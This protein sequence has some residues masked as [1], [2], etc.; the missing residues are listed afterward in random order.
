[1][2]SG[3]KKVVVN[4]NLQSKF[5]F[6]NA[7]Q[8]ES[9]GELVEFTQLNNS[10][11]LKNDNVTAGNCIDIDNN[12][13]S[14]GIGDTIPDYNTLMLSG[15]GSSA[16][17]G[18]YSLAD[19]NGHLSQTGQ[20]FELILGVDNNV[21]YKQ[22]SSTSW[23]IIAKRA[24]W[25]W[26]A[27]ANVDPSNATQNITDVIVNYVYV[28][29]FMITQGTD[30]DLN[31]DNA[32]AS[33]SENVTY[34]TSGNPGGITVQN[35]KAVLDW[36]LNPDQAASTKIFPS[37]VIKQY[38]DEQ[39]AHFANAS[40][41]DFNNTV[42]QLTG[43]PTK[44]QSA[45]EVLKVLVD[46]VSS[47]VSSNQTT[48]G[49]EYIDI[50]KLQSAM[51]TLTQDI[52][53]THSSLSDNTTVNA[54]IDELAVLLASLRVDVNT[55][56]GVTDVGS[57]LSGVGGNVPDGLDVK[58][59]MSHLAT[60]V[61]DLASDQ[62]NRLPAAHF[63]HYV[64]TNATSNISADQFIGSA[65][66]D[67]AQYALQDEF[68]NYLGYESFD[69][70]VLNYDARI[71]VDYGVGGHVN[72][73]IYVR[74][75]DTGT[76]SRASFFDEA[77]EI[78]KGSHIKIINGGPI[79]G[80]DFVVHSASNPVVGVDPIEF[81]I[82]DILF[83]GTGTI[84]KSKLH[85]NLQSELD[86]KNVK[87][88]AEDVGGS[89]VVDLVAGVGKVIPHSHGRCIVSVVDTNG[90][91]ISGQVEI[92]HNVPSFDQVTITSGDDYNNVLVTIFG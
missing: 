25:W 29:N 16:L 48:A 52:G 15:S 32:P 3:I 10:L 27:I 42:A 17:D 13:V 38:V 14:L 87:F 24:S 30:Q 26:A 6:I 54:L 59:V 21:Y 88:I 83:I 66:F 33:N 91:D 1:M 50:D 36:A 67:T 20:N 4:H 40:N 71:L 53:T 47:T 74:D 68:G 2:S 43:A 19:Y 51:G 69:L 63:Y 73:G 78:N 9:A 56:L 65:P 22:I 80:N 79:A 57:T 81:V 72:S 28:D 61:D 46:S 77:E 49:F 55:T 37:S 18:T 35:N 75:K 76:L 34:A 11:T 64:H 41:I 62:F 12:V 44:I 31:G 60:E 82:D 7:K 70:T 84:A 8:G 5:K 92:D 58:G 90:N 23:S 89:G 45:I 39:D 86:D 85:D